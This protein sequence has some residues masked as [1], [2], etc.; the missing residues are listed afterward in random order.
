MFPSLPGG[1]FT[2]STT[3][4]GQVMEQYLSH[5]VNLTIFGSHISS[6]AA[7]DLP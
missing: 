6:V 4:E 3:W 2:T 1:F 7:V 5:I